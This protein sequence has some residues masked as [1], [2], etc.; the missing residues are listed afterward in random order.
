M[1]ECAEALK[2]IYEGTG[3][4]EATEENGHDENGA[5]RQNISFY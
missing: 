5:G 3:D 4:G 2:I 1:A